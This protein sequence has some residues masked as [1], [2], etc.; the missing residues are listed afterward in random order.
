MKAEGKR[1]VEHKKKARMKS[2]HRMQ[3]MRCTPL[4]PSHSFPSFLET[5]TNRKTQSYDFIFKR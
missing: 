3:T 2:L 4:V 1:G 5:K